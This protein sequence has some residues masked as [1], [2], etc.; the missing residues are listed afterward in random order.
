MKKN[1]INEEFGVKVFVSEYNSISEFVKE[2]ESKKTVPMFK[3]LEASQL[4]EKG[5]KG[6]Y[7]T[8]NYNEARGLLTNGWDAGAKNLNTKLKIA[9]AKM[10]DKEVKRAV[11]DLVGFQASVP[12]YLQGIPQNMINKRTVKQKAKVITLNKSVSYAAL[13]NPDKIMEDSIKFLQI[14]QSL[15][16]QNVRVNV[17]V[18]WMC[19][20][21]RE[22]IF[23]KIK[24]KSANERLNISK[25]SFPLTHPS[26]LRRIMFKSLEV[27]ER[28][29]D[30]RWAT[31][32]GIPCDASTINKYTD[33]NEYTY[34]NLNKV[35]LSKLT[36]NILDLSK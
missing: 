3:G 27:E 16:K 4:A 30:S 1:T 9:N 5:R 23:Y 24:I 17:N 6:W 35:D 2:I 34:V 8:S 14:V 18:I 36:S 32:Y 31:G 11:Y 22:K 26:F 21:G 33:K 7:G 20:K 12:R 13:V 25:L 10:Q 28:I 29:T 15:E 19:E